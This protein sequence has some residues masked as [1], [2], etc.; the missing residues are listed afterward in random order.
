MSLNSSKQFNQLSKD[1]TKFL[2]KKDKKDNGIYF[3]PYDIIDLMFSN[4]DVYKENIKTILEPSA[5][6]CEIVD[7]IDKKFRNISI[8]GI[9]LNTIIYENIKQISSKNQNE[10]KL[11]NMD[12]LDYNSDDKYDLI[13]GNPPYV[14]LK[15]SKID[16]KYSKLYDGRPNLFILFIIHS[17]EKLNED[18]IISFILP[19]NFMNCLY[20]NKLRSMISKKYKI[21]TIIDCSSLNS[22]LETQ[23]D[24]IIF[25][26]Q[27]SRDIDNN[28]RFYL[29]KDKNIIYNTEDNII[30]IKELYVNSKTLDEMN[31]EVK[32]GNI[33][34][35]EHKEILTND[36]KKTRLIYSSDIKNNKLIS[37]NYKNDEKKNYIEKDGNNDLLLVV[38]RGYGKGKYKFNYCLID[39]DN[40]YLIENHLICL[41]YKFN[42]SREELRE[43]YHKIIRSFMNKKTNDFIMIYFGNNAINTTELQ[44]ILPIYDD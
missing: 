12:Y 13:I 21:L 39:I 18:G 8:T 25:I 35:N 14:V 37:V 1:L 9:E 16:K 22:Y 31:I 3:T 41:K 11:L 33:T 28:K 19:S 7:Y 17:L 23:Q 30:K 36:N 5:G 20:Y 44:Y 43:L 34:W 26:I 2:S 29:E 24:T 4:L 42:I 32:V 10:F 15:K 27:N 40:N 38:N 6:S